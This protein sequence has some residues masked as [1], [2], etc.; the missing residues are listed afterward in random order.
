M[1]RWVS[2]AAL[3]SHAV[4]VTAFQPID[5]AALLD[6][7]LACAG[8]SNQDQAP[9]KEWSGEGCAS[10]GVALPDW[11][12]SLVTDFSA[13]K[14]SSSYATRD[15]D[16]GIFLNAANFTGNVSKWDTRSVTDMHQTFGCTSGCEGKFN[17]DLSGWD[18]SKVVD[19]S[20]MF[21][22]SGA[23]N[24]DLSAW[25]TSSVTTTKGMFQLSKAFNKNISAWDVSSVT[26]MESMFEESE[27]FN[28]GLTGWDTSSVTT[29]EKMFKGSVAFNQDLSGLDFSNVTSVNSMFQSAVAFNQSVAGWNVTETVTYSDIFRSST[30]L[31]SAEW[32]SGQYT[33]PLTECQTYVY[34][35]PTWP[36]TPAPTTAP[37]PSPTPRSEAPTEPFRGEVEESDGAVAGVVAASSALLL[38]GSIF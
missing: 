24:Q 29:M 12:T 1:I 19:M 35:V 4:S 22:R 8:A 10:G 7:M 37:T 23:F 14:S 38:L 36:P 32:C 11:D 17:G 13:F 30:H 25:N 26:T 20:G 31:D 2:A 6:A 18:T 16:G 3:L 15:R 34:V 5:G 9:W 21:L 33:I 27:V 28:Q